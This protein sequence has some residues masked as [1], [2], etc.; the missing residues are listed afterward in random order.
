MLRLL[1]VTHVMNVFQNPKRK[2][3]LRCEGDVPPA[4]SCALQ[5]HF[6]IQHLKI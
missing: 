2:A 5:K 1:D 4:L 3:D 6:T